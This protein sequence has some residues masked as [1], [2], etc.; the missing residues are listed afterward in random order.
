[1]NLCRFMK[2]NIIHALQENLFTTQRVVSAPHYQDLLCASHPPKLLG[3]TNVHEI[4]NSVYMRHIGIKMCFFSLI[5]VCLWDFII[6]PERLQFR[7][8]KEKL[9][10]H[11]AC[12]S[13]KISK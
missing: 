7:H 9:Y 11:Q 6:L 5:F 1:M 8:S 13:T 4:K 2:R 12:L 3:E 10:E